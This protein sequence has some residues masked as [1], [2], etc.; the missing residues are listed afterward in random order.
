MRSEA[1]NY[2]Q[3]HAATPGYMLRHRVTHNVG[4]QSGPHWASRLRDR[5]LV[6][7]CGREPGSKEG[8][9]WQ[10]R[11][12]TTLALLH[13]VH[14]V[15]CGQSHLRARALLVVSNGPVCLQ[16]DGARD[17]WAEGGQG[18]WTSGMGRHPV[19][20]C[21]ATGTGSGIPTPPSH[22]WTASWKAAET[23]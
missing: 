19:V 23:S 1:G 18:K 20:P 15:A 16:D 14:H 6:G 4:G 7:A 3:I 17:V 11:R 9:S 8:R 10:G 12:L 13:D 22:R 21:G 5:A 2:V